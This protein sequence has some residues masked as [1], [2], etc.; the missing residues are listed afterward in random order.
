MKNDCV[1]IVD[2]KFTDKNVSMFISV[3]RPILML[4]DYDRES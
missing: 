3:F 1:V 2:A 4:Q